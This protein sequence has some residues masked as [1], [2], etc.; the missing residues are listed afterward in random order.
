M[1]NLRIGYVSHVVAYVKLYRYKCKSVTESHYLL[2]MPNG[3]YQC[4]EQML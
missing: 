4:I 1:H 2:V 3:M